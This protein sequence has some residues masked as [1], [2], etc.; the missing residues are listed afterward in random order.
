MDSLHL[1]CTSTLGE[2]GPGS[3]LLCAFTSWLDPCLRVYRSLSTLPVLRKDAMNV[4][5]ELSP[6]SPTVPS[7]LP[8]EAAPQIWENKLPNTTPHFGSNIRKGT[9]AA[10]RQCQ[11]HFHPGLVTGKGQDMKRDLTTQNPEVS[12]APDP[13]SS[14]EKFPA[15]MPT[16]TAVLPTKPRSPPEQPTP[17]H[18]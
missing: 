10:S 14:P 4:G 13:Q 15:R 3:W 5:H 11:G 12:P 6:L 2:P 8:R 1:R 18:L 7:N 9:D 17:P 16:A